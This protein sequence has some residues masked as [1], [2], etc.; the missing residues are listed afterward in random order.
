MATNLYS[1]LPAFLPGL[2]GLL[3]FLV[4]FFV[5]FS[6]VGVFYKKRSTVSAIMFI[7]ALS[8][9]CFFLQELKIDNKSL[10][11]TLLELAPEYGIGSA[12]N[13]IIISIAYPTLAINSFF[14][15]FIAGIMNV[16]ITDPSLEFISSGLFA[17]IIYLVLF[18]LAFILFN[19]KK[20]SKRVYSDY[21]S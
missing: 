11:V 2:I 13:S 14:V 20:K 1:S 3:I 15:S 7:L 6:I 5:L 16:S 12:L 17:M 8:S 18:V 4:I 10:S 9:I 19:R 21:L